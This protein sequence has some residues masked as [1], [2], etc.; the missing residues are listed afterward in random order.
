MKKLILFFLFLVTTLHLNAQNKGYLKGIVYEKGTK[1]TVIGATIKK[2]N[3]LSFGTVTDLEGRYYLEIEPGKYKFVCGSIGLGSDT[4]LVEIK[5]NDTTYKDIYL[6]DIKEVLETVVVSTSKYAQKL[7]EQV[8]SMEILKPQIIENRN[9]T[10]LENALE[11]VPGVSIIDGDPQIRGGSGFTFGVGSRVAIIVDGLPLLSGDA[12]KPEWSYI[13]MENIEQVEVIKGNSSVLYGSSALNGV[14]HVRTAYP[15]S[16]PKT[17]VN[18]SS[19]IYSVGKNSNNWYGKSLPMYSNV[20]LM[21][22]RIIKSHI[23]LVVGGNFNIDQGYIG[24]APKEKYIEP[25][26]KE[27]LAIQDSIPT[28]TNKDLIKYR[29][30]LNFNLRFRDRKIKGLTY[31]INANG[32]YNKTSL[33]FAW[34]NDKENIYE[35]YPGALFLQ[36][37]Y[38]FNVDPFVKYISENGMV[39]SLN[40]RIFHSD[41]TI[42]NNQSNK[43]T[44]YYAEYQLQKKFKEIDMNFTGG[45]VSNISTSFASLYASSGKPLNQ[46]NNLAAFIQLDKKFWHILNISAGFR[47]EYFKMNDRQAE[48]APILRVGANLQLAKGTFVRASSGQ[49]FRYPTI[50]ERYILTQTGMFGIFPNPDLKPEKSNNFEVGIKQGFKFG[51]FMGFVD[52]AIFYQKYNNMI[53]YLMGVWD[54]EYAL[55]GFKFLN[56]GPSR[57]RGYEVSLLGMTDEKKKFG[58]TTMIGYTFVDAKTL[59]PDFLIGV[60]NSF[61]STGAELTYNTT[62]MDP[63]NNVLKYRYKNMIKADVDLRYKNFSIGVTYRH[64]SNMENMDKSILDIEELTQNAQHMF[65][66]MY[67]SEFWRNDQQNVNIFDARVS[68]K[69]NDSHKFTLI[70]N[71]F[72]NDTYSLRP[73]KVEA[74]RTTSIQYILTL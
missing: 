42:T 46:N 45:L 72:L 3:D 47:Y 55:I 59:D 52:G 38:L 54:P 63:S 61:G 24:P 25:Y 19:G 74:P 32:M 67:G 33:A 57:V 37:S 21:H 70:C 65:Y 69:I 30:R 11:T 49:G 71:N 34:L 12:G 1:E 14:I 29:G 51:S 31:G 56:T 13:A 68:Y 27:A 23:D 50:T 44:L 64:Y 8:V 28:Y 15:R 9:S 18:V 40:T 6:S 43:G 17:V 26:I 58:V 53:E 16:K 36:E 60:D 10:S 2:M 7:E 35:T 4:L 62:S 22:S 66:P 48:T 73:L 39:H 5:L 20:N 41:N